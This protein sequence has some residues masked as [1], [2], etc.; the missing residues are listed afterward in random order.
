MFDR[1]KAFGL[2]VLLLG[3][4]ASAAEPVQTLEQDA[5]QLEGQWAIRERR[6]EWII[7]LDPNKSVQIA[8]SWSERG[9]TWAATGFSWSVKENDRG[10]YIELEEATARAS[11]LP[12]ELPYELVDGKLVLKVPDGPLKGNHTFQRD[13]GR[14]QGERWWMTLGI[15]AVI[16]VIVVL[17]VFRSPKPA[18]PSGQSDAGDLPPSPSTT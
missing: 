4:V 2:V 13:T 5:K 15:G 1:W 16:G 14:P 8:I 12:R 18:N 9:G 10:R 17:L 7:N 3:S 6:H 11:D